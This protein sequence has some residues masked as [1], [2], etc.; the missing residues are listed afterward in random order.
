MYTPFA[1]STS[2]PLRYCQKAY[3][4]SHLLLRNGRRSKGRLH[5]RHA[6]R[7]RGGQVLRGD[8]RGNATFA[9]RQARKTATRNPS[10]LR[11]RGE[12]FLAVQVC[13]RYTTCL[14]VGELSF[15][16]VELMLTRCSRSKEGVLL[17][18]RPLVCARVMMRFCVIIPGWWLYN[19][20][21]NR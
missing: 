18:F 14:F 9:E 11:S 19:D 12:S 1:P 5:R 20:T 13:F 4:G 3:N 8:S 2:A 15:V 7:G 6:I 10:L 17:E 16:K 21:A